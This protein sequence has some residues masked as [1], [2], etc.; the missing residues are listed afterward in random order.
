MYPKWKGQNAIIVS[1]RCLHSHLSVLKIVPLHAVS[2]GQ[3]LSTKQINL[4]NDFLCREEEADIYQISNNLI[5][6]EK[7]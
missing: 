4:L 2:Y 6:F 3:F 1:H 5:I 7:S